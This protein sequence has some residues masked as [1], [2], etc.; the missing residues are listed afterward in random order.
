M[1][2]LPTMNMIPT[3]L[4]R[5]SLRFTCILLITQS[6]SNV[7][8]HCTETIMHEKQLDRTQIVLD[9]LA[10]QNASTIDPRLKDYKVKAMGE[11]NF[12]FYRATAHLFFEDF[13]NGFITVPKSWQSPKFKSWIQGDFHLQNAGFFGPKQN[14]IY[15]LNDFDEA[16][17]GYFYLDM[18]RL[19]SSLYLLDDALQE[20]ASKQ[21]IEKLT[22][23]FV[24]SYKK[25]LT[26]E[27]FSDQ[28]LPKVLVKLK[29]KLL[30]KKD[31]NTLLD[32]WTV[33]DDKSR[34]FNLS[35][36]RL[37]AVPSTKKDQLLSLL[38]ENYN[39]KDIAMRLYSGLGSLGVEKYY[40]LDEGDSTHTLDDRMFELKEQ[41]LSKVAQTQI[42]KDAYFEEF[43]NHAQRAQVGTDALLPIDSKYDLIVTDTKSYGIKEISPYKK[44]LE[45]FKTI[46]DL[47]D[48][49]KYLG[50]IL[51]QS[52]LKS[53]KEDNSLDYHQFKAS[54]KT[55]FD[56]DDNLSE[57]VNLSKT[58]AQQV[59]EDFIIY[60][61][62]I[63]Y[64]D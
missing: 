14:L 24:S 23:H 13:A 3:N 28:K 44:G 30:K 2:I 33:L 19:M 43:D 4:K 42:D 16:Y 8:L 1:N 25:G 56:K 41:I 50:V 10:K 61:H 27:V 11:S 54:L 52:H 62:N 15:H 5:L 6:T 20:P 38:A 57:L 63:L 64:K 22:K 49:V 9:S 17:R 18:I 39:V 48:Y 40:F 51:A 21:Q 36:E 60:K 32:K 53:T 55:F 45:K 46:D 31:L 7:N 35:L 12:T 59:N 37:D 26:N 58:Y 34:Q 29:K 47:K